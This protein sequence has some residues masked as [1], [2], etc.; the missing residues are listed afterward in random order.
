MIVLFEAFMELYMYWTFEELRQLGFGFVSGSTNQKFKTILDENNIKKIKKQHLPEGIANS[1]KNGEYN[2]YIT[3]NE[4]VLYRV[5][6]LTPSG[7]AGA[8]QFGAFA[9][10]EFAEFRIDVKMR[11]ALNTQWKNALYIEEKIIV[12]KNVILNIGI[13]VPV[14]LLSGIILEGGADQVLLPEN[15]SEEWVVGYRFV[16]S[17]PVMDYSEYATK[18][19][20]EIRLE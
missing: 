9:T 15:W 5:Y 10:T 17:E 14:K 3:T 11:L 2:T 6:G 8:K 20:N 4:I 7:Q 12:P 13:V 19:S 16:T 1:F 18:K